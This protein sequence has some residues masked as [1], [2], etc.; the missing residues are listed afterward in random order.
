MQNLIDL[1]QP[2][3]ELAAP[4][5][6]AAIGGLFSYRAGIFNIGLEGFMLIAAFFSVG[7]AAT[8]GSL[9]IGLGTGVLAAV[10][11]S[12]V[13][14]IAVLLFLANEVIV[15]IAL[16]LFALGLTTFLVSNG[17]SGGGGSLSLSHGLPVTQIGWISGIPVLNDIINGRD[18]LVFV[19]WLSVPVAA[20]ILRNTLFGLRLR[21]VGES[22]LS[23][24]AAG[25]SVGWMKFASFII[26]GFFCGLAGAELSL[27]SV[28][29]FSE[30]MTSGRGI[31]AFA[32][33]IFGGGVPIF[34]GGVP[35][36]VAVAALLFGF[37]QALAAQVQIGSQFPSQFVLMTPYVFTIL[38]LAL[39]GDR[40]RKWL[41]R[42]AHRRPAA[43]TAT[44]PMPVTPDIMAAEHPL[45]TSTGASAVDNEQG[46]P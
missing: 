31:I 22:P 19:S 33:V 1:I 5:I 6:L 43:S 3:L 45:A 29:L 27:G 37:A 24:R 36:F 8:T 25:V 7:G 40:Q 35:I 26:S 17:S 16:N 4:L 38:A 30:N 42:W 12:A 13:M 39:S 34:G 15:G 23:A 18:P 44:A 32:A 10:L 28:Y 14:G 46:R 11:L 41:L 9:W 20:F 2:G 21:A